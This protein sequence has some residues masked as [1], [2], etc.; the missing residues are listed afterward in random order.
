MVVGVHKLILISSTHAEA[1]N[2]P[3]E[4]LNFKSMFLFLFVCIF[5]FLKEIEIV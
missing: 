3:L 5:Y 1:I 4:E 2:Y